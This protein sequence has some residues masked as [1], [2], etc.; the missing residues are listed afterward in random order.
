[1]GAVRAAFDRLFSDERA[2]PLTAEWIERHRERR[3]ADRGA[4]RTGQAIEV[5]QEDEGGPA[6]VAPRPLQVEALKA[7]ERTRESGFRAGLVVLA[8]G[9]AKTWLAAFDSRG[10]ERVPFVAHR[11]EILD[12][13]VTVFRRVQRGRRMGKFDGGVEG[14][15][16]RRAVC[17]G[18]PSAQPTRALAE[19]PG[20]RTVGP[21]H[22][23][24]LTT[25]STCLAR[26]VAT[27]IGFGPVFRDPSATSQ[28][29]TTS[30]SSPLNR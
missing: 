21:P 19:R 18:R 14:P 10:F 30:A 6:P 13:A 5:A 4:L 27:C 7:L 2:V 20:P 11:G 26:D 9:L 25:A 3:R 15:G 29:I 1:L 28:R 23:P 8:A 24:R 22:H 17:V 12:Q 16:G